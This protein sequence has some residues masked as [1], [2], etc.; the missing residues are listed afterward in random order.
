ML[1]DHADGKMLITFFIYDFTVFLLILFV[2]LFY[3][4]TFRW[5][6]KLLGICTLIFF[7][8]FFGSVLGMGCEDERCV[9]FSYKSRYQV[10]QHQQGIN[11]IKIN[12]IITPRHHPPLAHHH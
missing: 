4:G 5:L 12:L 3:F 1:I 7:L 9:V 11:Q 6:W 2:F 10:N 8:L